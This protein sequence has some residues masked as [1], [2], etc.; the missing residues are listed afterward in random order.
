LWRYVDPDEQLSP[1]LFS[2]QSLGDEHNGDAGARNTAPTFR[3][4]QLV[5]DRFFSTPPPRRQMGLTVPSYRRT[6]ANNNLIRQH[7][8]A[9]AALSR[10]SRADQSPTMPHR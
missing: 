10:D 5:P 7:T 3:N 1:F 2:W 9:A 4:N 8:H 6:P